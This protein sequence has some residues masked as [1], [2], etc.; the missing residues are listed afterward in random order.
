MACGRISDSSRF[1]A[2]RGDDL[3]SCS[4]SSI[5]RNSDSSGGSSDGGDESG[6]DG[7]VQS[8]YKGPLDT[9]DALEE[10]LPV[11][12]VFSFWLHLSVL[13]LV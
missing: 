9:M 4:S 7:E 12:Y 13:V 11:K 6:G 8:L 2:E 5:G 1:P 10:V 3:D